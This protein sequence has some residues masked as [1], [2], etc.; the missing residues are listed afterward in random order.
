[1]P[2]WGW[3]PTITSFIEILLLA[4]VSCI[5]FRALRAGSQ[6]YI[7][8][9]ATVF[10][11]AIALDLS[12]RLFTFGFP[13][14]VMWLLLLVGIVLLLVASFAREEVIDNRV[15][16]YHKLL[17]AMN[18][19]HLVIARQRIVAV[20]PSRLPVCSKASAVCRWGGLMHR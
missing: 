5:A 9:A 14:L 3:N 19:S 7:S 4:L 20:S 17:K 6:R 13:A 8:A 18:G 11:I 1:M 2:N 15:E 16:H 12:E 10:F